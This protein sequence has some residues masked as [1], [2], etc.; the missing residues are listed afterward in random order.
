M[1]SRCPGSNQRSVSG[2][3]AVESAALDSSAWNGSLSYVLN[4]CNRYNDRLRDSVP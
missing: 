2:W 1:C 4:T 3:K